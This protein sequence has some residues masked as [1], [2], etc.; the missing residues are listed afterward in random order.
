[1][2]WARR[3]SSQAKP[4]LIEFRNDAIYTIRL[5][6]NFAAH[7]TLLSIRRRSN[8]REKLLISQAACLYK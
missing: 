4:A 8:S 3:A 1:M 7:K 6:I 5:E 2:V